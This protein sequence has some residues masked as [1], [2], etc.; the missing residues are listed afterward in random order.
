MERKLSFVYI[1]NIRTGLS[2]Y[3]TLVKTRFKYVHR[4]VKKNIESVTFINR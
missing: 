4:E 2:Q 3:T 1:V